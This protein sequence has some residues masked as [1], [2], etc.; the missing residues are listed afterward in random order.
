MFSEFHLLCQDPLAQSSRLLELLFTCRLGGSGGR[1]ACRLQ[2]RENFVGTRA[3]FE[4]RHEEEPIVG[5]GA[6]LPCALLTLASERPFKPR[7]SPHTI[8]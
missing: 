4:A 1:N 6:R 5:A 7:A 8:T 3:G 2:T